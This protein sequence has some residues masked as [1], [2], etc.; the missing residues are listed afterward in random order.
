MLCSNQT[1]NSYEYALRA[2]MGCSCHS[3]PLIHPNQ[4]YSHLSPNQQFNTPNHSINASDPCRSSTP[5]FVTTR[6]NRPE[7]PLVIIAKV[8]MTPEK[9]L[10]V[11][12]KQWVSL[13]CSSCHGC[14]TSAQSR[15]INPLS[16]F[17]YK[18]IPCHLSFIK[19]ISLSALWRP[20]QCPILQ[21]NINSYHTVKQGSK[22]KSSS[23]KT[24]EDTYQFSQLLNKQDYWSVGPLSGLLFNAEEHEEHHH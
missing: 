22:N 4:H 9:S 11:N 21:R 3:P 15:N 8:T 24:H 13:I 6:P 12:T 18:R 19:K 16:Q 10:S 20:Q 5:H 14:Q 17:E 7:H 2:A 23:I 1:V